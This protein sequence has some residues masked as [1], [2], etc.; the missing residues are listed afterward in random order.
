MDAK[1]L[2]FV[3]LGIVLLLYIITVVRGGLAVPTP[4]QTALGFVTATRRSTCC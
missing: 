1:S 3:G 2:L 4:L